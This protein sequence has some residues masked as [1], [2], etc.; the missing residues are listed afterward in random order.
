[1]IFKTYVIISPD[2]S[3]TVAAVFT[4]INVPNLTR[5]LSTVFDARL[6]KV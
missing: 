3:H 1:M 5:S 4:F 6:F 2:M